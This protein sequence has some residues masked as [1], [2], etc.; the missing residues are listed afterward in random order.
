MPS[1]DLSR[2]QS[3]MWYKYI[4]RQR[5]TKISFKRPISL[6]WYFLYSFIHSFIYF[7]HLSYE[8]SIINQGDHRGEDS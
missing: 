6:E 7:L 1:S 5:G 3:H 2:D 4:D 8:M